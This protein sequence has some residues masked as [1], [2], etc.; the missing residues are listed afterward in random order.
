MMFRIRP[1]DEMPRALLVACVQPFWRLH[2]K[3]A[4]NPHNTEAKKGQFFASDLLPIILDAIIGHSCEHLSD[5]G[6]SKCTSV[7]SGA[8][9][10][11]KNRGAET[12]QT[13]VGVPR[14]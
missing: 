6:L 9:T 2:Q 13:T 7:E 1:S 3:V 10:T 12:S 11:Q 5:V 14:Q 4:R 8:E